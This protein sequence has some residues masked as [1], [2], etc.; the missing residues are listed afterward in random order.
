MWK[1]RKECLQ[2]LYRQYGERSFA[3]EHKTL[4]ETPIDNALQLAEA[5]P[6]NARLH[7]V[8]HSRGGLVGELLC[9]GGRLDDQ[10]KPTDPFDDL[11]FSQL[12]ND[13]VQVGKLKRLGDLLKAK[14]FQIDR[15]VR[16]ACPARG[17]SLAAGRIDRLLSLLSIPVS[18][19]LPSLGI[20]P[21]DIGKD[22]GWFIATVVKERTNPEAIPGVA[23]QRPDSP[24]VS[25]LNRATVKVGADLRVIGSDYRSDGIFLPLADLVSEGVFAG[26]NDL[27]VNTPS[28]YGGA[29]RAGKAW[30]CLAK[31]AGTWH[32]NYFS[33]QETA[34]LLVDALLNDDPGLSAFKD[35]TTAPD[36]NA[37][38]ARGAQEGMGL[39]AR[40][41]LTQRSPRSDGNKPLLVLVPGIMG[42]ELIIGQFRVWV[43]VPRL[44]EGQ[45]SKFSLDN[46]SG[47]VA[48]SALMDMSYGRIFDDLTRTHEVLPF[49]YDW[50]LSLEKE[51]K[52]LADYLAAEVLPAAVKNKRPVRILAHSMGGLLVRRAIAY[53]EDAT[54][55]AAK[56]W[57]TLKTLPCSRFIMSGTPNRGSWLLPYVL[58]GRENL[59]KTLSGVDLRHS[60][61]DTLQTIATFDGFLEMMPV[62]DGRDYFSPAAWQELR[63]WD[64]SGLDWPLPQGNRLAHCHLVRQRIDQ[65]AF[66]GKFMAYIAGHAPRTPTQPRKG[67]LEFSCTPNGDG[68]VPWSLGIPEGCK[69]YYIDAIHGDLLNTPKSFVGIQELLAMGETKLLTQQPPLPLEKC[70]D[71]LPRGALPYLPDEAMVR[72]AAIGSRLVPPR[73][74]GISGQPRLKVSIRHSDLRAACHPVA[75]GHYQGDTII[76]A[77]AMLDRRLGGVLTRNL[78]LGIYPGRLETAEVFADGE[79]KTAG[80]VIGLGEVGSLTAARLG[81][82]FATGLLRLAC[83]APVSSEVREL[84]LSTLLIGTGAGG[85]PVKDCV[86]SLIEAANHVNSML[87]GRQACFTELEFLEIYEDRALQ[88]LKAIRDIYQDPNSPPMDFDG[89]LRTGDGGRSRASFEEAPG[90]WRRIK[91]EATEDDTLK[92]S[93]LT[94]LAR[95]EERILP[96]QLSLVEDFVR[97]AIS[98]PYVSPKDMRALFELVVPNALKARA[99]DR[100]NLQLVVDEAAAAYPWEM[101]YGSDGKEL[102]PLGLQAGLLRQL[103][104]ETF[105]ESVRRCRTNRALV[106]GVPNPGGSFASLPGVANEQDSTLKSLEQGNGAGMEVRLPDS[107]APKDVIS[108]LFDGD[109]RV[110]HLAGH[111]V[112]LHP[113]TY[114]VGREQ[115]VRYVSGMVLAAAKAAPDQSESL[116]LLTP[117][118]V[119][120]MSCVPELVFINCCHLGAIEARK[121]QDF[122]EHNTLAA[123]LATEFIRNG[124]RA[125]IAAGWAVDDGAAACFAETFYR[126]MVHGNTFGEAVQRAR[127]AAFGCNAD[128]TTWAAYQCYGDP[129]YRFRED[130]EAAPPQVFLSPS[131]ALCEIRAIRKSP[132][133]N[134]AVRD[135]PQ[136]QRLD[137]ITR[138]LPHEWLKRGELRAALGAAY[139]ELGSFRQALV[140]YGEAARCNDGGCTLNDLDLMSDLEIRMASREIQ[141][142]RNNG[143]PRS[144]LLAK[145]KIADSRIRHALTKLERRAEDY[146]ETPERCS[147]IGDGYKRLLV[148]AS[149]ARGARQAMVDWYKKAACLDGDLNPFGATNWVG[150]VLLK[151]LPTAPP[152][153]DADVLNA[154]LAAVRVKSRALFR[155]D[156]DFCHGVYEI[157]ADLLQALLDGPAAITGEKATE[158]A[159]RYTRLNTDYRS[160]RRFDSVVTNIDFLRGYL[161]TVRNA[162]GINGFLDALLD[163]MR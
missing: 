84:T 83:H 20:S 124:V 77:E 90:W 149:K 87:A 119:R 144:E 69:P 13:D 106:V 23:A 153:A 1:T 154:T 70:P 100:G 88:A 33:R 146:G 17:T 94:D 115:R 60:L 54:D 163:A 31:E 108:A 112:Y 44:L 74:E 96:T 95:A 127:E 155:T 133:I 79:G 47:N 8:S 125:V 85:I 36:R 139:A 72:R 57:D 15:F 156:P 109:Y 143:V 52:R 114:S 103:S 25:L 29:T 158:L 86:T 12:G 24:L 48:P 14:R 135:T 98:N 91:I 16:V 126:H 43:D 40:E 55:A 71:I 45:F 3:L 123:N 147:L 92:F 142:A 101:M 104:C 102:R 50:R 46:G 113:V 99:G 145:I 19:N 58:A 129:A 38:I 56:W 49:P 93:V 21:L 159:Q 97:S 63:D 136:L 140:H 111:G 32:C 76:S 82:A 131:E 34:G 132:D 137:Q 151:H 64:D 152:A 2:R 65:V 161:A 118:E 110:L 122:S 120:Q 11:D 6:A 116:V 67:S 160:S 141:D 138:N 68:R 81:Q 78:A 35:I 148:V 150:A 51:G 59:V 53:S 30:Y 62:E 26:E 73:E 22:I 9:R 39:P 121:N 157:D 134:P 162:E 66:D 18:G 7:L 105:R 89:Q 128:S 28:M 107:A 27:V 61:K 4:T 41:P 80:I 10:G 5:L 42:S 37:Y 117:A 130:G 75:V